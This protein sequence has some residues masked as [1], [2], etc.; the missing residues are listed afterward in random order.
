[1][2]NLTVAPSKD[3]QQTQFRG[4]TATGGTI[5][6]ITLVC[7]AGAKLPTSKGIGSGFEL[8]KALVRGL[9]LPQHP[10]FQGCVGELVKAGGE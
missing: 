2:T 6:T 10:P 3:L 5:P 1:M 4:Q 9:S 8:A 7:R